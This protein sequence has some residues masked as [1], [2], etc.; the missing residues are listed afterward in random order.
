MKNILIK[1]YSK[2]DYIF[3]YS[4]TSYQLREKL[5][6]KNFPDHPVEYT[7]VDGSVK[8]GNLID[9]ILEKLTDSYILDDGKTAE[10]FVETQLRRGRGPNKIRND[11]A[12][13][14]FS[15]DQI[16]A[17]FEI[18]PTDAFDISLRKAFSTFSKTSA[19]TKLDEDPRKQKE[20]TFRHLYGK[21]FD[22]ESINSFL[23]TIFD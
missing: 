11:L 21:G 14:G 18:L 4:K 16:Y 20:K 17:I 23:N 7:D 19:F 9:I 15:E 8:N 12:Q 2:C 5:I 3:H 13:K 10:N 6:D 1:Y 22:A